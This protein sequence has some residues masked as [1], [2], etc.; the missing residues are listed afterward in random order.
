MYRALRTAVARRSPRQPPAGI[1]P[2]D[3]RQATITE[4]P[5]WNP[6]KKRKETAYFVGGKTFQVKD[7]IKRLG[8]KWSGDY[9][10]WWTF[11]KARAEKANALLPGGGGGTRGPTR[12]T[13]PKSSGGKATDRQ[14]QYAMSLI[15][16]MGSEWHDTDSGQGMNPPSERELRKWSSRDV[17]ALIDE[18]REHMGY[19]SGRGRRY[20]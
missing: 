6:Q 9:K 5:A 14:V 3:L 1:L 16:N 10:A 18:L 4:R 12:S 13:A 2:L 11:D 7:K 17:S 20:Y 8:L 15:R 19:G